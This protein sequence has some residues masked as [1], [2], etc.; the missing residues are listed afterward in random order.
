MRVLLPIRSLLIEMVEHI[1][2]PPHLRLFDNNLLTTTHEDNTSALSLA[3]DQHITS[4]TRHYHV[5]WHF[6]WQAV[7]DGAVKV[8]YVE[9]TNQEADYLTKG[10]PIDGFTR[11]R[12]KVQGW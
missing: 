10:L 1:D 9:T 2:F 5:R 12:E 8:I 3:T 11:I 6:F 4:R 7:Q